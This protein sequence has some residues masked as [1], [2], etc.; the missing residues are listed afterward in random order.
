MRITTAGMKQRSEMEWRSLLLKKN[1]G[2]TEHL[3]IM[4][5]ESEVYTNRVRL[6]NG[7]SATLELTRAV[8]EILKDFGIIRSQ[9][10]TQAK[11]RANRL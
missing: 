4:W 10:R 7:E 3:V 8:N 11:L 6:F 9:E 1:H 5:W 2:H